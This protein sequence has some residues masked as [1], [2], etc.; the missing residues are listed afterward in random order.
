MQFVLLLSAAVLVIVIVIAIVPALVL[1]HEIAIDFS[2]VLR[3]YQQGLNHRYRLGM[4]GQ[5]GANHRECFDGTP[6]AVA[7]PRT[8]VQC[9]LWAIDPHQV[10]RGRRNV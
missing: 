6:R 7:M 10:I 3:R 5:Q 2:I 9:I 4:I 8:N 1:M